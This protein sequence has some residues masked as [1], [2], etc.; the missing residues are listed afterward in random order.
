MIKKALASKKAPNP[1][2][3]LR[4][5]HAEEHH[6][7][8][9]RERQLDELLRKLRANRF[10]AVVGNPGSGKS[11]LVRCSLIPKL[12]DGFTGQAGGQEWRIA[13]SKPG[14]NPFGHLSTQLAQ[15]GALHKRESIAPNYPVTIE[16]LLRRGDLGL[17]DAVKDRIS[18]LRPKDNLLLVIDQFDE[19]F[20]YS[21][22]SKEAQEDAAA[23]VR[24]LLAA[25]QQKELPIYVIITMRS[26]FLGE[27]TDFRGLPEAIND[28][29][30][31][32]PRMKP[33]DL[34]RV[35][36]EPMLVQ[37][38]TIDPALPDKILADCG[39]DFDNLPLLQHAL[40][41]T[42]EHWSRR[43]N[44]KPVSV[45]NY[46]R[47]GGVGVSLS[48]HAEEA[49]KEVLRY[50]ADSKEVEIC[51]MLF[52]AMVDRGPD[53][54]AVGRPVR[55]KTIMQLSEASLEEVKAVIYV[56]SQTG[57]AFI[58]APAPSEMEKDTLVS[59]ANENLIQTWKRLH[60]WVYEKEFR[61]ADLYTR[62]AAT[63]GLH[64]EGQASYLVN[65]ELQVALNWREE[66]QPNA[67]WASRY[68]E[69]R[70]ATFLET[71]QFLDSSKQE[72]EKRVRE[73]E[74][75]QRQKVARA[76][77]I[78]TIGI[79][80]GVIA[81]IAF[82]FGLYET[83]N[84]TRARTAADISAEEARL[85]SYQAEI[86]KEQA[87]KR[88][89]EA[90]KAALIARREK[91]L[92]DLATLRALE[93]DLEAR[94]NA[95]AANVAAAR[96]EQNF[97][98]AESQREKA[99]ENAQKALD[100]QRK[101][102]K[103]ATLA[104]ER[105]VEAEKL[106]N[107]NQA[108]TLAIKSTEVEN[109][110][111]Q[112]LLAKEAFDL[113]KKYEGDPYD[114]YVY[115]G[116][117]EARRSLALSYDGDANHGVLNQKPKGLSRVGDIRAFEVIKDKQG[118]QWVYTTGSDGLLLK[119]KLKNYLSQRERN[120]E[121]PQIIG[122]QRRVFRSL[123]ISPDGRW[124]IRGGDGLFVELYDMQ[125][126][127][128]GPVKLNVHNGRKV[129]HLAFLPDSKGFISVGSDQLIRFCN[130]ENAITVAQSPTSIKDFELSK[131]GRY[132]AGI[133]QGEKVIVW[134]LTTGE[135]VFD[136]SSESDADVNATALAFSPN[137]RY[138][139]VGYQN[140]TIAIWDLSKGAAAR[141]ERFPRVHN[142]LVSDISFSNDGAMFASSSLDKTAKLWVINKKTNPYTEPEFQPV[143]L[144][145]HDS[146][147]SSIGFSEGGDQVIS[148]TK[149]GL[150]YLWPTH[151][152]MLA[153][154]LCPRLKDRRMSD[155]DWKKYVGTLK[156]KNADGRTPVSA[157]GN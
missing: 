5:Y 19:I 67:F 46:E 136:L 6:L 8:F 72:Q 34:R 111:L 57:R 50:G 62:L 129:Y 102:E 4:A 16:A 120:S 49:Y 90:Q 131:D 142:A 95:T 47:M 124:L 116:L 20:R 44:N 83:A 100:E 114:P 147:V 138:I 84:A 119:W 137:D 141:P 117:M 23:F 143:T 73:E 133:G 93:S 77:R 69:E 94:Q 11:S 152:D 97:E 81:S 12:L 29:Q 125:N 74:E 156:E 127:D 105:R 150:L 91:Q 31:L 112:G 17:V 118:Q 107:I 24:L 146:W 30:F 13:L 26:S 35:I 85:Q 75:A 28:G 113:N 43:F 18:D 32:V 51:E 53:G 68:K 1:Y 33:D 21:Q 66:E 3:G 39:E 103:Q 101:A 154:E 108:Q 144:T 135:T 80:V 40:M 104:E 149:E 96:A 7:F 54:R 110:D 10:L 14:D 79:V 42:W 76:R 61:F 134:D 121:P 45:R 63:A 92:A 151:A 123:D 59:I 2:P 27:C 52:R 58:K 89:F 126:L 56:F 22:S 128:K 71:M 115:K 64:Y 78:A 38:A 37:G 9:G 15:Q 41:R 70:S 145:G 36:I 109:A 25:A 55:I 132:L 157:C 48:R 139:S 130:L 86:S 99:Y 88:G 82:L 153:D 60:R 65:P 140:G 106:R 148:A 98:E 122:Q 155:A 87:G